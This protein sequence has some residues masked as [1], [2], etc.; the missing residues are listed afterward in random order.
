[1]SLDP[2]LQ[3][4]QISNPV[5]A[6]D[7][8]DLGY[9]Q[10]LERN[11]GTYESFAAGFSF[12]S[13]LTTVF[14]LFAFGFSFAGPGFFWTWPAV[15][16]GQLF[17]AFQ[18]AELSARWPI[19]G[20]IYQ[21][22]TRLGGRIWGWVAGWVMLVAQVVTVAVAAIA[23]QVVLP[24][25]WSGFQFIGD[26]PSLTSKSG[27]TNA[28]VLGMILLAITTT[29]NAISVKLMAVI[30]S[31]GV[32]CELVGVTLLIVALLSKSERGPGIV[33][34]TGGLGTAGYLPALLV[35]SLMAG[36]VL[37]GFDSA[38]ELSEETKD[39]RGT[40][41][42]TIL[43]ALSFSGLF[44]GLLLLAALMASP[45]TK[46]DS[47]VSVGGMAYIVTARLGDVL[48]RVF[49]ADVVIAACVC[50]LAIQVATTRM[51]F[52]MARDRALP[53]STYLSKVSPR[54]HT[55]IGPAVVVG[56]LT[57]AVLVLNIFQPAMYTA[58]ASVC[59][60][61][62]YIAYLMVT[63]PLLLRRFQGWPEVGAP[64]AKTATGKELF[65]LGR[66]ALPLN[67]LAVVWGVAM[68]I[69]LA[70][71]RRDVYNPDF[72]GPEHWYLQY[73]AFVFLGFTLLLGAVAYQVVKVQNQQVLD[74]L[75]PDLN[76]EPA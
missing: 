21:W 1:M 55:P 31:V 50:T 75:D 19:S 14:Q 3:H 25:L 22:S 32:T 9:E 26:D 15:F 61:L 7:L 24:A 74:A 11:I 27:S 58:L 34:N 4:H 8:H 56:V 42:R 28:A 52:S 71:P 37:V 36:Y 5:E 33:F 35:A 44:G 72:V 29:I 10:E 41:P 46:V 66:W 64:Q 76:P 30:N 51:M 67:V 57:M 40:A 73:F 2:D 18:F 48:G 70:W 20:A 43:R 49:I 53:F 39:A 65:R 68:T 16:L 47:D 59:I 69:N 17:V 63:A 54:T 38:A 62:L 45:S 60:M 12:V 6:H 13:I 23:L